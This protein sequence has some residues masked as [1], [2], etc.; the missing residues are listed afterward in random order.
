MSMDSISQEGGHVATYLLGASLRD[1]EAAYY[2]ELCLHLLA[3]QY[4]SL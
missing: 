2:F 4:L 1:S 3:F